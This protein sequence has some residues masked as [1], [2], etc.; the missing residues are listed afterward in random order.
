M[1]RV[2]RIQSRR[3]KDG[4]ELFAARCDACASPLDQNNTVSR[5][6]SAQAPPRLVLAPGVGM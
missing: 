1:F 4:L 6:V 3:M 2:C 5:N